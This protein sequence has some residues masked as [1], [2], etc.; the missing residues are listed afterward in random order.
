MIDGGFPSGEPSD[1]FDF[2]GVELLDLAAGAGD[3][4]AA[5][6][7]E[8]VGPENFQQLCFVPAALSCVAVLP[9]P[10]FPL[11]RCHQVSYVANVQTFAEGILAPLCHQVNLVAQIDK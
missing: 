4:D 2:V 10:E 8:E 3:G 7:P 9:L 6:Q 1:P 5:Q 11:L